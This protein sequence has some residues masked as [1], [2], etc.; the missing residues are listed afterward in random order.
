MIQVRNHTFETNSSSVHAICISNQPARKPAFVYTTVYPQEFGWETEMYNDF[1]YKLSYLSA[2]IGKDVTRRTRLEELLTEL[3]IVATFKTTNQWD[4][5]GYVDHGYEGLD[6]VDYV[7]E[8]K[9]HL[10]RFLLNDNSYVQTGND[11]SYE[12]PQPPA[13][14]DGVCFIKDN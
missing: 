4:A 9:D 5:Y 3:G 14:Y 10:G 2:L 11:N 7:L 12:I 6:F 8:S 13:D 1:D